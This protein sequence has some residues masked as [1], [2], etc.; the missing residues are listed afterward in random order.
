[1]ESIASTKQIDRK[2]LR[3][4]MVDLNERLVEG[5]ITSYSW[6]PTES[7]WVDMLTKEMCLPPTLEDVFLKN[8]LDL[9]RPLTNEVRAL[10]MEIQ[11]TNFRNR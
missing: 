9:P 6:L 3:L 11:L 5:D 2:T 1:M 8:V 7:M 10:E 4:T